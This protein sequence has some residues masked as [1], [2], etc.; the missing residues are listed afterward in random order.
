[1]F[2][3]VPGIFPFSINT[4]RSISYE[5]ERHGIDLNWET[6]N[7][8]L[9]ARIEIEYNESVRIDAAPVSPTATSPVSMDSMS[10]ATSSLFVFPAQTPR[11]DSAIDSPTISPTFSQKHG[12]VPI[13]LEATSFFNRWAI[14]ISG[15]G[16]VLLYGDVP[17][18]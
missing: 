6:F 15:A 12:S 4:P 8:R 17:R 7:M 1:M 13:G 11:L 18:I 10:R 2:S 14:S 9:R 5:Y 3:G 16:K